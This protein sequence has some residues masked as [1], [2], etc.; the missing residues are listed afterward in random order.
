MVKTF[1]MR[2]V[3]CTI[4]FSIVLFSM[5]ALA[6]EISPGI[7][8]TPDTRFDNLPDFPFTPNYIELDGLRFHYVDEG[9]RDGAAV[10]LLHGEPTWSYLYRHMIPPLVA[11]G[12]RVIA[13]DLMGF[14][15][16]DK[17]TSVEDHSHQRHVAQMRALVLALDLNDITMFVQDWGGLIGLRVLAEEPDR[18]ARVIV[19]NTGLPGSGG[20][21]GYIG[22]PLFR[23]LL[24]WEGTVTW[25]ELTENPSFI[26][27]AAYSQTVEDMPVGKI[28]GLVAAGKEGALDPELVTAY[29]APF[30]DARYKAGPRIMPYLVPSELR[31][32]AAAWEVLEQWEKP[33][34]T[35]FSDSDPITRGGE[36]EFQQRIPGARNRDHL[37]IQGAGHFLQ[38]THGPQLA[39]AI[40]RFMQEP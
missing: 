33:F 17:P 18:F 8:R 7:F 23:F 24:W 31:E 26:R 6:D 1:F 28:V 20:L 22:Y 14:G 30:P 38:E 32:N 3:I 21:R 37:T 16:S 19:A 9:P 5:S 39:D 15:R 4:V 12:H 34:L 25:E 11:A 36:V 29:D 10:L 35:A 27:W 13:P 40:I 2:P